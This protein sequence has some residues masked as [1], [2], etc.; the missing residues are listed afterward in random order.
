MSSLLVL[1]IGRFGNV[2]FISFHYLFLFSGKVYRSYEMPSLSLYFF[3]FPFLSAIPLK[4]EL[5]FSEGK[6]LKPRTKIKTGMG[7]IKYCVTV[8]KLNLTD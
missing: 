1:I 8:N 5:V 6:Y 4:A 7:Y 3:L 2:S